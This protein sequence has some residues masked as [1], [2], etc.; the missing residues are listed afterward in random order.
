MLEI[1]ILEGARGTGKSTLAFKLRQKTPETTLVNPTGFHTD[2]E[3]GLKKV[4]NYYQSW[5]SLL[6]SLIKHDSKFVF[7]RFYFSEYV[8]S[9]LYK[10]YDFDDDYSNLNELMEDLSCMGV[11]INVF[12]LTINDKQ[13]LQSR[14]IRD[15]VPFANAKESVEQTLEQQRLYKRL[16]ESFKYDFCNEN[17]KIYTIDTSGKTN[18]EVYDEILKLKT[19]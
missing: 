9:T 18:D 17:F 16:F 14:L 4:V 1:D 7:D 6:F 10:E 15:K 12:F 11:K 8:Y 19:T 2:G 3:E 13:E 5:T